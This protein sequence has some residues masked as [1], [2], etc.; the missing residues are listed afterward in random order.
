MAAA[1]I[2]RLS[3]ASILVANEVIAPDFHSNGGG[4][5]IDEEAVIDENE[6][7][8]RTPSSEPWKSPRGFLWIETGTRTRTM[9][10]SK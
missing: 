2:R 3:G 9:A 8:L 7:L 5:N 4:Q 10:T 1:T 6:P